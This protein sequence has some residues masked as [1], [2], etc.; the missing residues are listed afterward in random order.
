MSRQ[1]KGGAKPSS[2]HTRH[3]G[4]RLCRVVNRANGWLVSICF[5][6]RRYYSYFGDST[7]GSM[8]DARRAANEVASRNYELHV[9]L[10]S[11]RHR[12][13]VR[14][15][16][17]SGWPGVSRYDANSTRNAGWL[18]YWDDPVT[19][20]RNQKWFSLK[21]FGEAEACRLARQA[22]EE[23]ML[24]YQRRYDELLEVIGAEFAAF[25]SQREVAA[26]LRH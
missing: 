16:S 6:G 11:L 9:E 8:D 25:R 26:Q 13:T 3:N 7:Y 4:K 22:R 10:K 1:D 14:N 20:T 2:P 17:R 21:R 12:F 19:G 18:A 5:A 15:T 24:P 23:A